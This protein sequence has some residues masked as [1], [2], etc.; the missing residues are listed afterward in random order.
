MAKLTDYLETVDFQDKNFVGTITFKSEEI[1]LPDGS[2]AALGIDG[3]HWVLVFQKNAGDPFQVFEYD[4]QDKS[5]HLDKKSGSREDFF[6][7]RKLV[8]YFFNHARTEDLIT[9]LP[10]QEQA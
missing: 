6:L 4:H 9:L 5:I 7:F 1:Y 10:P 3:C 8:S 2:K